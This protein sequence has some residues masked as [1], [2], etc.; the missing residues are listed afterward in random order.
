V[1]HSRDAIVLAL[2][3]GGSKTDGVALDLD[4]NVISWVRK[5]GSSVGFDDL[6][7]SVGIVDSLVTELR[8]AAGNRPVLQ[9]NV[10]LSGLDLPIEESAYSAA[11][12]EKDWAV[13]VTGNPVVVRNDMFA[14]LRAGSEEPNAVAVV[15][16][17]GINCVGVREDGVHFRFMAWGMISGDCGGGWFIGEQALWHAARAVDGRGMSTSLATSIPVLLGMPDVP[18]VVEAFHF[19]RLPSARLHT[20]A[21]L[22]LAAS[23]AG[24]AIANGILDQQAEEIVTMAVTA[25]KRLEL[26]GQPIP[27]VLGG[28]IIASG[29]SRLLHGIENGL[30]ARAPMACIKIVRSRPILGA[31]LLTLEA[32]GASQASLDVARAALENIDRV[33]HV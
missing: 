30:A 11:L 6:D 33:S 17:T 22:V 7:H 16:G 21:P 15:C 10:Y 4:G 2:D 20:F 28:G 12:A 25:L 23:D 29:N 26:A 8:A 9:T 5:P 14:L 19:G 3:G 24:D 18:S 27:V 13:G 32:V 31:A 1:T